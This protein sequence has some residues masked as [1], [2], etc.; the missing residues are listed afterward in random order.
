MIHLFQIGYF[1]IFVLWLFLGIS[2]SFIE[3]ENS[4]N[5]KYLGQTGLNKKDERE[6]RKIRILFYLLT[7]MLGIPLIL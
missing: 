2:L 7:L 1:A 5:K 6:N 4:L 3:G